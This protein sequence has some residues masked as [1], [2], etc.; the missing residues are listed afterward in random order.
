M[1]FQTK[2]FALTSIVDPESHSALR[3]VP[4]S[5]AVFRG[6]GGRGSPEMFLA[7]SLAPTFLERD[8]ILN[9]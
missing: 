1:K 6:P 7:P 3:Q 2:T 4:C 9:F 8:E 5:V